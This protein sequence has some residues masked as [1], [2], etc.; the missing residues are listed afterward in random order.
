MSVSS[1]KRSI[2]SCPFEINLLGKDTI[3]NENKNDGH[4]HTTNETIAATKVETE[5]TD[6]SQEKR[7]S[8]S[9]ALKTGNMKTR[10]SRKPIKHKN[11]DKDKPKRPLS[12]YNYFFSDERKKIIKAVNCYNNSYQNE[13]DPCLSKELIEKLRDGGG[14][15]K[16][17]M[18]GKLIGK[19]WKNIND[20]NTTYYNALAERDKKRYAN[21]LETYKQRRQ[22][23]RQEAAET[24][25]IFPQ[26]QHL[27]P[28]CMQSRPSTIHEGHMDY[29]SSYSNG[30]GH[31]RTFMM[32]APNSCY[33]PPHPA[34]YDHSSHNH[35]ASYTHGTEFYSRYENH[36]LTRCM[37]SPSANND[38][39]RNNAYDYNARYANEIRCDSRDVCHSSTMCVS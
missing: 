21:E 31:G 5:T 23:V 28:L 7:D 25:Y 32:N 30:S 17:E 34:N 33:M 10:S 14:K 39:F 13:I 35:N 36:Y 20:D 9:K 27:V 26:E 4:G 2:N 19:R 38:H 15:V 24:A 16:F 3:K 1:N 37:P 29:V 22:L 11:K 6:P 8:L 18:I 12:A